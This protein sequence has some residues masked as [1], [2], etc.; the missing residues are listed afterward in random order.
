MIGGLL[1]DS[2]NLLGSLSAANNKYANTHT[3]T[4]IVCVSSC[5]WF[6]TNVR[7]VQCNNVKHGQLQGKLLQMYHRWSQ[8]SCSLYE[9]HWSITLEI[10]GK[11]HWGFERMS[12]QFLASNED[13]PVSFKIAFQ[14]L[15]KWHCTLKR[16]CHYALNCK[17]VLSRRLENSRAS[18]TAGSW[19]SILRL[20]FLKHILLL[21]Q[22][23]MLYRLYLCLVLDII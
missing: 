2:S 1:I 7:S 5:A 4:H 15:E 8:L 12:A 10:Q 3:N 21:L 20:T 11:C 18:Q 22:I 23:H 6:I 16:K 13:T 17:H 14:S 19:R 9:V